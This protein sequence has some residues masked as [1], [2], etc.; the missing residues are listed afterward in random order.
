MLH[1]RR[2]V[3]KGHLVIDVDMGSHPSTTSTSSI[4]DFL[5]DARA[6]DFAGL[7]VEYNT[8]ET[9]GTGQPGSV[10]W[11]QVCFLKAFT[12]GALDRGE[13]CYG[14]RAY[15]FRGLQ[16]LGATLPGDV[17]TALSES[18][19]KFVGVGIKSDLTLLKKA[20]PGQSSALAKVRGGGCG[21]QLASPL[22]LPAAQP[23]QL[24]AA[25]AVCTCRMC[26]S[27][28]R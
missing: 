17:I 3:P 14:A 12:R 10:A 4:T 15:L 27:H 16:T 24:L 1:G 6:H 21:W 18:N 5:K 23:P 9:T 22:Q 2:Q 19:C 7:D 28:S 25:T 20:F 11:M 8:H 26:A 13:K